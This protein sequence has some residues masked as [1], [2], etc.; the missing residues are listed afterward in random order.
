[1][2]TSAETR[3]TGVRS[4]EELDEYDELEL[5]LEDELDDDEELIENCKQAGSEFLCNHLHYTANKGCNT[6]QKSA[7]TCRYMNMT[8]TKHRKGAADVTGCQKM[9]SLHEQSIYKQ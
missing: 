5:Q 1:M 4:G 2:Y 6:L 8:N 3:L 7:Y 9:N